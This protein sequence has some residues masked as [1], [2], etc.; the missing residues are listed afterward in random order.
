MAK[1]KTL[2]DC[3]RKLLKEGMLVPMYFVSG[4]NVLKNKIDTMS[5]EEICKAFCGL[6]DPQM[7]RNDVNYIFKTLNEFIKKKN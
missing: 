6:F 2:D 7:V 1:Q 4:I 5:D 3:I